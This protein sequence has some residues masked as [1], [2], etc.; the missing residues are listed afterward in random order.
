M[1]NEDRTEFFGIL[2]V[3]SEALQVFAG[4]AAAMIQQ[5]GGKWPAALRAEKHRVQR[6][7]T[8]VNDYGLRRASRLALGLCQCER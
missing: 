5:D 7:R 2:L 8:V 1:A 3:R 6:S 4:T